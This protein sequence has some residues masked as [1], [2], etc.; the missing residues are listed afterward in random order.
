MRSLRTLETLS[1]RKT[2][3]RS[4]PSSPQSLSIKNELSFKLGEKFKTEDEIVAN[5]GYAIGRFVGE[6]TFARVFQAID[7]KLNEP[8]AVKI[9]TFPND[10]NREDTEK[11]KQRRRAIRAIQKELYA[12][13]T[14]IH[15]H[16]IRMHHYFFVGCPTHTKLY[17]FMQWGEK[18]DMS[19]FLKKNGPFEEHVCQLWMAQMLSAMIYVHR[20]KIAHRDLKLSNI[21]LDQHEDVLISDFGLCQAVP[22]QNQPGLFESKTYCGTAPY[23]APELFEKKVEKEN[24]NKPYDPMAVDVWALGV[25]LYCLLNSDYPFDMKYKGKTLKR[26][27]AKKRLRFNISK[28]KEWPPSDNLELMLTQIFDPNPTTRP[29]MENLSRYEWI[30]DV[31]VKVENDCRQW[32]AKNK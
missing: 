4:N 27:R 15:P 21:L 32:M 9:S 2:S 1:R 5:Q 20:N 24:M 28:I 30:N 10:R 26:M 18:G 3:P 16:I 23:M 8:V 31:Y 29:T 25:I 12:F 7:T 17:L 13:K 11:R 14:I 6:G 19:T 22:D